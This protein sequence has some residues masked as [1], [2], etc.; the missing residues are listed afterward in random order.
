LRRL[1][2]YLSEHSDEI[3]RAGV[4]QL[5]VVDNDPAGSAEDAVS[6]W[7]G[8]FEL[9]YLSQPKPG[10]ATARNTAVEA[11]WG[12]RYLAFID[13]DD[14]PSPDWLE[15][16]LQMHRKTGAGIVG[17]PRKSLLPSDAPEWAKAGFLDS[18]RP[19]QSGTTVE[20]AATNNILID[21]DQV[22]ALAPLFDT[23]FDYSGGEDA[24]FCIR[25]A[26]SG[27]NV[28]WCNEARMWS[29]VDPGRISVR[30]VLRRAFLYG[31]LF[32]RRELLLE[33]VRRRRVKIRVS[34]LGKALADFKEGSRILRR[35]M[36]M[37]S[38]VRL[39]RKLCLG[40]G[41]LFGAL[42]PN[43]LQPYG[44]VRETISA[45]DFASRLGR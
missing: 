45:L 38:R 26:R 32:V 9:R 13:D 30:Y 17:G 24:V 44:K 15:A 14:F 6:E 2:G 37:A 12:T 23:R 33:P 7:T 27:V 22:A 25:A 10:F 21:L 28:V 16:L 34:W 42:V 19:V 29:N 3:G 36:P 8:S 20:V 1:L 31:L 18:D 35:K 5:I 4:R 41:K 39:A 40:L 43:A 11:A